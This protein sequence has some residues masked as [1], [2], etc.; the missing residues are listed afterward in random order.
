MKRKLLLTA[1]IIISSV[2]MLNAQC[3]PGPY[4]Q[5]GIYPDSAHNLDT[6]YV[7]IPYSATI[8]AVIP[9]DTMYMGITL[10]IDSIGVTSVTGL[11]AGFTFVPNTLTGFWHGGTSGCALISGTATSAEVG[12]YHL[13]FHIMAYASLGGMQQS[14]PST[15]TSYRLIVKQPAGINELAAN[16]GISFITY[17]DPDNHSNFVKVLSGSDLRNASIVVND[18][19]GREMIRMNNLNGNEFTVNRGELNNGIY[20]ISLVNDNKIIA[21]KKVMV[22]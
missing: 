19:T 2:V 3:T 20:F 14:Q 18:I 8:T 22:N 16:N 13:V 1:A 11:P 9:T 4:T 12:T 5:P 15:L 6:A 17:P 21:R 7:G 10:N